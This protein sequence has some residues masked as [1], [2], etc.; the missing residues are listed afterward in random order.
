MQRRLEL[1]D[2]SRGGL[3]AARDELEQQLAAAE[4]AQSE[5]VTAL[6]TALAGRETEL[7]SAEAALV[8]A[9]NRREADA[10]ALASRGV[11]LAELQRRLELADWS[12]GGLQ[13]TRDDLEGELA[14][15]QAALAESESRRE[16]DAAALASR[17]V[18]LAELQRRLELADWTRGGL[19]A[20]RDELEQQL[21]AAEAAQSERVTA[22]RPRWP[23][24]RPSWR[25]PRRRSSR[26][27]TAARRMRRRWPRVVWSSPSCSA[28]WSWRT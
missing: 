13:A 9:E 25:P 12:R 11:E 4:A 22:C 24:A 27:R 26:R 5:R 28:G 21:A 14:T 7:A 16:A 18:E 20:S 1:A 6:Q 23:A 10:A 2:W 3:Q 15:A 8:E 19:Q 17:G